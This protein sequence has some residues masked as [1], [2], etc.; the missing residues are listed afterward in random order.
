MAA[1]EAHGAHHAGVIGVLLV[2]VGGPDRGVV[3]D[4]E[5]GVEPGPEPGAHAQGT[6]PAT[7]QLGGGVQLRRDEVASPMPIADDELLDAGL[8]GTF[9]GRV[10]LGRHQAAG[11]QVLGRARLGLEE[12]DDP[13]DA[14]HVDR[15]EDFQNAGK[16]SGRLVRVAGDVTVLAA[17]FRL[18]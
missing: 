10:A 14:L 9:D 2:G 3:A 13:R 1:V 18:V 4:E 7:D 8:E 17:L 15:D 6:G 11:G 16:G 12:V 5:G